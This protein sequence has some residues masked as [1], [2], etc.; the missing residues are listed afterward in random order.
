MISIPTPLSRPF[1]GFVT[2]AALLFFS[3]CAGGKNQ[4]LIDEYRRSEKAQQ[5]RIEALSRENAVLVEER[6]EMERDLVEIRERHDKLKKTREG[7]RAGHK[8]YRTEN[9]GRIRTLRDSLAAADAR[10]AAALEEAHTI[11]N[12]T[13]DSLSQKA[14]ALEATL[15]RKEADLARENRSLKDELAKRKAVYDKEK[16]AWDRIKEE[17][18]QKLQERE[19]QLHRMENLSSRP[20]PISDSTRSSAK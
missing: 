6:A 5:K 11:A 7:E 4:N 3:A 20:T 12:L 16:Y 14:S 10:Q 18:F 2:L 1:S 9:E 19:R 17:L 13:I 8:A 15:E